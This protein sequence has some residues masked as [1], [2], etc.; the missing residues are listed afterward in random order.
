M[1]QEKTE[2]II[3]PLP[4]MRDEAIRRRRQRDRCP[5]CWW[6]PRY[7]VVRPEKKKGAEG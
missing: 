5:Y 1:T 2:E 7:R 6:L 4:R 3:A